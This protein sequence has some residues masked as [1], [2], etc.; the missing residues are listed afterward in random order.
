MKNWS[1]GPC[2]RDDQTL[3]AIV[4]S[5]GCKSYLDSVLGF[6][7]SSNHSRGD[8]IDLYVCRIISPDK[9]GV[10]LAQYSRRGDRI[11]TAGLVISIFPSRDHVYY[12]PLLH[13]ELGGMY[14]SK[15]HQER[16][17][18]K[19]IDI[20]VHREGF[21]SFEEPKNGGGRWA[22]MVIPIL[23]PSPAILGPGK[24]PGTFTAGKIGSRGNNVKWIY[25][26]M[27]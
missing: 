26:C 12:S 16:V 7:I 13:P 20:T 22:A 14:W 18:R 10:A 15:R 24:S 6:Q 2:P 3:T 19:S 1:V 25:G 27:K 17:D 21:C 5:T 23:F 11:A 4:A 8:L 9:D